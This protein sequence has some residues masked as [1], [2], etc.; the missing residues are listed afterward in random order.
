MLFAKFIHFFKY[1]CIAS[2]KLLSLY[3]LQFFI[4]VACNLMGSWSLYKLGLPWIEAH[5]LFH[6]ARNK[7]VLHQTVANISIITMIF[8]KT[9]LIILIKSQYAFNFRTL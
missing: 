5:N 3:N 6:I 1:I 8:Y 4:F 9:L 2:D 7:P